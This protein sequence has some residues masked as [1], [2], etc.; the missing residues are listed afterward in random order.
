MHARC[1]PSIILYHT[2][3]AARW[4]RYLV[5][6]QPTWKLELPLLNSQEGSK[7]RVLSCANLTEWAF[8]NCLLSERPESMKHGCWL[9][10]ENAWIHA[11]TSWNLCISLNWNSQSL[12]AWKWKKR[13]APSLFFDSLTLLFWC[14]RTTQKTWV[15]SKI[16]NSCYRNRTNYNLKII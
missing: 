4:E 16:L 13:S 7:P 5:G 14:P 8:N 9:K 3:C 11:L 2:P 15:N 10:K 12:W 6:I 1:L